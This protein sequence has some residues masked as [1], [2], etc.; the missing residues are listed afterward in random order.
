MTPDGSNNFT[1]SCQGIYGGTTASCQAP[2]VPMACVPYNPTTNGPTNS[3]ANGTEMNIVL[4][5][6]TNE[7]TDSGRVRLTQ[8]SSYSFTGIL[9]PTTYLKVNFTNLASTTQSIQYVQSHSIK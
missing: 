1:W 9:S 3:I 8:S 4:N 2:Y 7:I 5:A 6:P